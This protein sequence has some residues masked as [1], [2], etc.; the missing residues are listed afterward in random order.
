LNG[1]AIYGK[2]LPIT[3]KFPLI[4]EKVDENKEFIV[5]ATGKMP[6]GFCPWAWNKLAMVVHLQCGGDFSFYEEKGMA[7]GCCTDTIRLVIFKIE[8]IEG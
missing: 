6:E 7:L 1:G 2:K 5:E 4:C 8:R 3:P